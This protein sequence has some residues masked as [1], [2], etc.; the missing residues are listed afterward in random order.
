MFL[1]NVRAAGCCGEWNA[2]GNIAWCKSHA[3]VILNVMSVKY[4]G[5]IFSVSLRGCKRTFRQVIVHT[6]WHDADTAT[7]SFK[8]ILPSRKI[9][10]CT[11]GLTK[12]SHNLW[13]TY[14]TKFSQR[15]T[16]LNKAF[17]PRNME[18]ARWCPIVNGIAKL[19]CLLLFTI[20]IE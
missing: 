10:S 14:F 18:T 3:V 2:D 1:Q 6:I 16:C 19:F 12:P 17:A 4:N 11:S 13:P 8:T 9:S 7:E 20:Y 15:C 5:T